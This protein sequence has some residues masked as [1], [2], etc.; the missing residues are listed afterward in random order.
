MLGFLLWIA[1]AAALLALIIGVRW[2]VR[3]LA[4]HNAL[5]EASQQRDRERIRERELKDLLGYPRRMQPQQPLV[6]WYRYLPSSNQ[7]WLATAK[8]Q[9]SKWV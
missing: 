7:R 9:S 8:E 4:P 5:A 6:V 3:Y 2:A 1:L